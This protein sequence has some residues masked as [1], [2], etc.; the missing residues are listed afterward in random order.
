M[1]TSISSR[2]A[3]AISSSE[4]RRTRSPPAIGSNATDG[5]KALNPRG[6]VTVVEFTAHWC[7]PC[8]NS[9]PTM[10]KLADSYAKQGVQFAFATE[11]YGYIGAK[12]NLNAEQEFEGDQEYFVTDHDIHC[13]VAISDRPPTPNPGVPYVREPN[14]E[15]YK[16]G[17]IPQTVIIDKNGVIRRILSGWDTGNAERI[18]VLLNELLKEKAT[19]VTPQQQ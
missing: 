14:S 12:K 4:P 18:P 5:A 17:G 10:T 2:S 16:V 8:R 19:R 9:Y 6:K 15:N 11:F 7:I 1:P 3:S 13:P